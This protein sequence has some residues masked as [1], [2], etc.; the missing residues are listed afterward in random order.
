MANA[1]GLNIITPQGFMQ[2]IAEGNDPTPADIATFENQLAQG[3]STVSCLVYNVQT[4]TP[5]TQQLKAEAAQYEIPI[6]T[7]SETLQPP[8]LTFQN[9]MQGEVAGL[10]NC[11]NSLALG[12]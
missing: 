4:L 5:I 12:A 7:V 1:T 8:N 3:N 6:T 9:W 11:L 2:A 10:A